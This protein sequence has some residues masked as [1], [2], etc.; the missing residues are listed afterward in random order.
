MSEALYRVDCCSLGLSLN[1]KLHPI[2]AWVLGFLPFV[3]IRTTT[4]DRKEPDDLSTYSAQA[5]LNR[6][7]L[8]LVIIRM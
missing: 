5:H 8:Q 1:I 3:E 2:P 4:V 7:M 6:I